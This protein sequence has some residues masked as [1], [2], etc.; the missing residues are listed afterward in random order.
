M[1]GEKKEFLNY[2]YKCNNLDKYLRRQLESL[3][4]ALINYGQ[5]VRKMETKLLAGRDD[6]PVVYHAGYIIVFLFKGV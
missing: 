5:V 6:L 4:N 3:N 1:L 2:L